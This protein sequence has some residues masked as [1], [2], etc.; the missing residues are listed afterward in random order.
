MEKSKLTIVLLLVALFLLV[1][2]IA[3]NIYFA[4]EIKGGEGLD[5]SYSQSSTNVGK[6]GLTIEK[7]SEN[8]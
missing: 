1:V 7:P 6:I 8:S 4:N 2:S 5:D 3:I